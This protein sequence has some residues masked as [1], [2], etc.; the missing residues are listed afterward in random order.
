[1]RRYGFT[2][3]ELLVVIAIIALL[4]GILL[5]ALGRARASSKLQLCQ[6]NLRGQTQIMAMYILDHDDALPPRRFDW[7]GEDSFGEFGGIWSVNR[8]L[9]RYAGDPFPRPEFG[10]PSPTGVWRCPNVKPD[11]DQT[12][13]FSHAGIV[14]HAPNQWLFNYLIINFD[15][16]TTN[17]YSDVLEGWHHRWPRREQW[18][19]TAFIQR[20]TEIVSL[21]DN[22]VFFNESHGHSESREYYGRR[23]EIIDDAPDGVENRSAHDAL[24]RL[25]AV[26][27]DGHSDPLP[28]TAGFWEDGSQRYSSNGPAIELSKPEVEHLVWFV[29]RS[30]RGGGDGAAE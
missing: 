17:I 14:H 15:D 20:P 1:M 18:R 29:R 21:M 5:P 12:E 3:I 10:H 4:V 9:A 30:D 19:R 28:Q 6:T 24:K 26:Y 16:G 13:R 11:E 25:P 2:L 22:I 7:T 27:L 8:F 23:N